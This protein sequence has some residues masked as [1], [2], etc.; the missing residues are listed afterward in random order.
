MAFK[1]GVGQK[2][3]ALEVLLVIFGLLGL[4]WTESIISGIMEFSIGPVKIKYVTS[5]LALV[6][7]YLLYKG[8][9]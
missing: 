8:R 9:M 1:I 2:R 7:A 3:T 4:P 6:F 5:A